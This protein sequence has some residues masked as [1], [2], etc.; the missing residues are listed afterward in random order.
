MF[1]GQ[2][3]LFLSS[4]LFGS[5]FASLTDVVGQPIDGVDKEV[6]VAALL[7]QTVV[8]KVDIAKDYDPAG[9]FPRLL[10]RKSVV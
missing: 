7:K 6:P 2:V 1:I 3:K 9:T 5:P 10:D 8:G 4:W